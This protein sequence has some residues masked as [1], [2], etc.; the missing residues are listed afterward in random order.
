MDELDKR[1]WKL[2]EEH[3]ALRE[4]FE[5]FENET[6]T[7]AAPD[8][9]DSWKHQYHELMEKL[10]DTAH[11]SAEYYF[12]S[13]KHDDEELGALLTARDEELKNLYDYSKKCH[14]VKSAIYLNGLRDGLLAAHAISLALD[15]DETMD[16]LLDIPSTAGLAP[17]VHSFRSCF[18]SLLA[19]LFM[20]DS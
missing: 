12:T 20:T 6:A 3:R 5:E 9:L 1:Y 16:P 18:S 15:M 19:C 17:S 8:E 11:Q 10:N 7:G 2:M 13:M 4:K 14:D